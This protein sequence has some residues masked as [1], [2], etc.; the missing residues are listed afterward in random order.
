MSLNLE[1]LGSQE[2]STSVPHGANFVICYLCSFL[3]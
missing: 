3:Y 2:E 1:E